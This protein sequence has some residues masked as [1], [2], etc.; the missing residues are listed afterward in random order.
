MVSGEHLDSVVEMVVD[1]GGEMGGDSDHNLV[2]TR[3]KDKF[4]T[5]SRVSPPTSKEG[6]D[7]T[8]DLDWSKFK[9]IVVQAVASLGDV[10]QEGGAQSLS[11]RGD[12]QKRRLKMAPKSRK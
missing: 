10:I 1:Q 2:V 12:G 4:I 8:E 7:I 11:S 5:T 6:W 9:K 3:I